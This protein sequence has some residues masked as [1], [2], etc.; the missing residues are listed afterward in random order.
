MRKN[1]DLIYCIR[2]KSSDDY[3]FSNFL[4]MYIFNGF[5]HA[6]SYLVL[7]YLNDDKVIDILNIAQVRN[8]KGQIYQHWIWI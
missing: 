5:V 8:L 7:E 2:D 3:L 4:L 6:K 1:S